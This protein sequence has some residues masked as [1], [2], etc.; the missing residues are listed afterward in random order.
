M[1][2]RSKTIVMAAA[3]VGA[4]VAVSLPADAA[5]KGDAKPTGV[6]ASKTVT[7]PA[8]AAMRA[9]RPQLGSPTTQL[10][11]GDTCSAY[12]DGHGDFCMWYLS[13][14]TGSRT[15]FL[16]NDANLV[17]DRFVSTGSGSGALVTNNAESDWNYDRFATVFVATSPNYTGFIGSVGPNTGGNFSS[18]YKNNVESLY[19]AG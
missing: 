10:R 17:D 7:G 16:R 14:F 11:T 4:V 9:A 2:A 5:P 3:G 1:S 18:T 19:W 8:N 13:N 15:G 12:S 6:A